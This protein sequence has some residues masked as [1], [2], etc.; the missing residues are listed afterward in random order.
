MEEPEHV[1]FQEFHRRLILKIV[2]VDDR[3]PKR[4][5]PMLKRRRVQTACPVLA[6]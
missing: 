1:S 4:F 6:V 5:I 3:D 2:N